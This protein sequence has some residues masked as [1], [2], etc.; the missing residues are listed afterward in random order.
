MVKTPKTRHSKP[1]KEPVTIDLEPDAVSRVSESDVSGPEKSAEESA[2]VFEASEPATRAP[3]AESAAPEPTPADAS[4][5]DEQFMGSEWPPEQTASDSSQA[6]AFGRTAAEPSRPDREPEP[7]AMPER[8]EVPRRTASSLVAGLLGGVIAL[9]GAGG[10][11]LA[12][13]WP[14]GGSGEPASGGDAVAALEADIATLKQEIETLK[15]APGADTSVLEQAV[16]DGTSRIDG[17]TTA[18]DTVKADIETL[19]SA[20]QSGGAGDGAAIEAINSKIS[21]IEQQIAALGQGTSVPSAELSELTGKIAAIETAVAEANQK[22]GANDG[23]LATVEQGIADL[24]TQIEKLGEQPKV[25]MALAA[26]ALKAAL[27]RGGPFTA[28]VETFAAVA[29]NAPELAELRTIAV[30]GVATRQELVTEADAAAKAMIAAGRVVDENAGFFARLWDSASSLV[31]VRPIGAVEGAGVPETVARMEQA[32]K[33]GDLAK[34]IAEYDTLPEAAK[35]AGAAYA[36]KIRQR[37][38]AEALV[39]K[40]L[41]GALKAA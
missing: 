31:S 22:A 12:G 8:P 39:D 4:E 24:K 25:A 10:L 5:A 26:A 29:P 2:S 41:A 34:A 33:D 21:Q 38:A 13:V 7:S 37:L 18:L 35:A 36:D 19:K 27:D 17:L 16:A 3:Q 14:G 30:Q 6:S 1:Q 28:E 20:V 40:A 11:Q 32:V 23:R 15:S 9:A